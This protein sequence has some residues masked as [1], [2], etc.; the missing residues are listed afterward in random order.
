MFIAK[1]SKY[2][3]N[4]YYYRRN[5]DMAQICTKS[6]DAMDDVNWHPDGG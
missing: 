3:E 1:Y 4:H 6:R 5:A 2:K